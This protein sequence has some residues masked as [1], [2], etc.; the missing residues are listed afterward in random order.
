MSQQRV[1][2]LD[3]T[4]IDPL[5]DEFF[6][7]TAGRD[8]RTKDICYQCARASRGPDAP[9]SWSSNTAYEVGDRV[10]PIHTPGA[11]MPFVYDVVTAGT[12]GGTEPTWPVTVGTELVDGTVTFVARAGPNGATNVFLQL[13]AIATP[14][15]YTMWGWLTGT[16][17][18]SYADE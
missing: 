3:G 18:R 13:P 8:G 15:N 11:F 2:D 4:V 12:S 17:E 1:C 16:W 14:G 7:V 5:V 10:Y 9:V 6:T